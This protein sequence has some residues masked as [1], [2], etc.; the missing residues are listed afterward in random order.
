MKLKQKLAK[1]YQEKRF[2]QFGSFTDQEDPYLT[3]FEKFRELA[4]KAWDEETNPNFRGTLKQI[5]EE[6]VSEKT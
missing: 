2:N 4:L 3:A 5:G 1:E 6:E